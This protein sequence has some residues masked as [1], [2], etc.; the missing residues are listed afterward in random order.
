MNEIWQ[1]FEPIGKLQLEMFVQIFR[2]M[3]KLHTVH[4]LKSTNEYYQKSI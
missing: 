2:K 4:I 1:H 3:I